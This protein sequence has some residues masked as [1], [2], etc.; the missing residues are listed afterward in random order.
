MLNTSWERNSAFFDEKSSSLNKLAL[1]KRWTVE[2]AASNTANGSSV[3]TV[4]CRD[5]GGF[6]PP[7]DDRVR[8][9]PRGRGKVRVAEL[10]VSLL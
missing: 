4:V 8:E 6:V 10:R 7:D 1:D 9:E 2:R 5:K 3:R